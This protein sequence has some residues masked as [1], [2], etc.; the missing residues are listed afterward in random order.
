MWQNFIYFRIIVV[1]TYLTD[2][3]RRVDVN[4]LVI[5]DFNPLI[6]IFDLAMKN[7]SYFFRRFRHS[8]WSYP[9]SEP[10]RTFTLRCE[11]HCILFNESESSNFAVLPHA[12]YEAIAIGQELTRCYPYYLHTSDFHPYFMDY[13]RVCIHLVDGLAALKIFATIKPVISAMT[14]ITNGVPLSGIPG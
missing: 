11:R 4:L 10:L 1:V 14:L 9:R 6:K 12:F 7:G 8:L 13:H 3:C 5:A 2:S